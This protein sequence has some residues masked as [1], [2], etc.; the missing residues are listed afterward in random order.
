MRRVLACLAAASL[1]SA[2]SG[3]DD[4]A[5]PSASPTAKPAVA[6]AKPKVTVPK[7]PAPTS[8][9]SEDIKVGTGEFVAPG[10]IATVHYVGVDYATGE[11]FDASWNDGATFSFTVGDDGVIQGWDKGILGMRVGGQRRLI[12]PPEQAYGT[13]PA[14]HE[15]GG[16]TL[17]F[18]IDL[19]S[20]GGGQPVDPFATAS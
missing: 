6:T 16:K 3:G 2:C 11:E 12:I 14:A 15:L 18:V 19:I 4:A 10:K 9:V 20:V 7:S 1:L 8:L 13:D 17:L 5:R